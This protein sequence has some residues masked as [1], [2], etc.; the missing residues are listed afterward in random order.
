[1]KGYV[2]RRVALSVV[3]LFLLVTIVFI[4]VNL[5]PGDIGR[6]I[7]G[8]FAPQE[9]V[10]QINERLGVNDPLPVQYARLLKS[11]V[12]FDFGDSFQF[13]R[14]VS[15]LLL[16]A[17][18][19]S[20]KLVAFALVLTIPLGIMAG[21]FAARRRNTAADRS[22]VTLG[23]ASSSIPDFVSGVTLQYLIG[24]K[25]GLLPVLALAPSGSGPATQLRYLL[26]PALALVVVYFGYIAR[27]TRAGTIQ[28]LDA[29]YTRTAVMKG[30]DNRQVMSRHVMRNALQPTVAVI[31][32]QIGYL[33]G[34]LVAL[35]R[36]FNYPGLGNL[37]YVA[38]SRKD[39]PLLTA[40][41]ILVGIIYMICTLAA[42][43]VIA[44]MNPRA[45]LEATQRMTIL[46]PDP[47][48]AAGAVELD[49]E[50][51]AH[52]DLVMAEAPPGGPGPIDTR[53]ERRQARKERLQL[54]IR[55][56]G[57]IIGVLILA[58][59]LVCAI[60][61]Y[62]ITPYDPLNDFSRPKLPPGTANHILGTD[63]LGRDVLSRLMAG[64]RDVLI[65][66]PIAAVLSVGFGTLFGLLMGYYRG[67]VDE[68]LSRIIEALLSIPV[69]LVAL[70]IISVLGSSRAVVIGTVVLL[71]TPIV[72]RT[73]RAA[74]L[75]EAQLDYV[76][77]AKLRGESGLF[78]M[79]REIMPN[80]T[81]TM[82][83]EFTV[84]VGYAVFTI[85][86]LSFLGAGIQ[87]PSPDWGLTIS[88]TYG[89]IQSG[90]W[91]PSLF[92][93]LAIASLVIATNLVADSIDTVVAS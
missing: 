5:L 76:T 86:T 50:A 11:T 1:M 6:Q 81:A 64:A 92:P 93:A 49:A 62:R 85:A 77:S 31:G 84:R 91:W 52:E 37:I 33:F 8:P 28:A 43:L 66:A 12:T 39:I 73:I 59:W 65:A 51:A 18:W 25:L 32:V 71:F 42:D 7:A 13:D 68:V 70:L 9:T 15:G 48:S 4:I 75:T 57:F 3:T 2:L 56:P 69:I 41:V 61:G 74:V 44:W 78:V 60:G 47:H 27:M 79:T 54:L 16:S 63:Q 24:V 45:R 46:P 67:W 53:A 10:D 90:Q 40:A 72:T 55:R 23:L 82:V 29:D 38:A 36:I 14:P 89:L 22:I 19:R 80:I 21:V 26:L 88:Q 34:G 35:E 30:L 20:A 87:P 58:V 83:V 17:L